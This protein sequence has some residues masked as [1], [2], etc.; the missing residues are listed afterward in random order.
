VPGLIVPGGRARLLVLSASLAAAATL[1]GCSSPKQAA[2]ATTGVT[3][4]STTRPTTTASLPPS[5][6]TNTVPGCTGANYTVAL[7]GTQGA[8]GTFEVT[9]GL[10]NTSSATCPLSG[11]PG[12]QL[13]DAAGTN[14]STT[15]DRGG[16]LSFTDFTAA[17]VSVGPGA[18][19]YFNMAYSD[20][21]TGTESSCPVAAVVQVIPPNTTTAL[22][23]SGQQF[24]VC[25]NGTVTVSPVFGQ[26]SPETQTTAPPRT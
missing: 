26:G 6:T 8:A 21:P 25:D 23:V 1:A 4:S 13:I 15:T 11:Y 12:I 19:A 16:S 24:M 7:L 18:T 2:T 5:T 10:R 22:R 20:V 9:F 3:A 17:L 14:I